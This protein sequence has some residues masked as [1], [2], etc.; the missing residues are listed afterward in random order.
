MKQQWIALSAISLVLAACGGSSGSGGDTDPDYSNLRSGDSRAAALHLSEA[1]DQFGQYLKNGMR[2]QIRIP[3]D[4]HGNGNGPANGNGNGSEQAP[5][6]EG[7]FDDAGGGSRSGNFSTTNVHV[8]GVDEADRIKY[9]GEHL[10]IASRPTPWRVMGQEDSLF[11]GQGI[12][13]LATDP[14]GAATQEVARYDFADDHHLRDL[15]LHAEA[16]VTRDVITLGHRYGYHPMSGGGMTDA[17]MIEPA[18][19]PYESGSVGS[20][21]VRAIDVTEP[22]Q[23]HT[24]WRLELDGALEQS[25]RVDNILYLVTRYTPYVDGLIYYPQTSDE[26]RAN[27]QLI[28]DTPVQ[29]LLPRYRTD[30]G[31]WQP[32]VTSERCYL[33]EER[34]PNDGFAHLV[35]IAAI[36][37][38]TRELVSS[39]C[40]NTRVD[41]FHASAT[42]LYLGAS[43]YA[44]SEPPR[45]LI[46]KF[47][48][49]EGDIEY[50]G[51]GDV[52]GALG[53][54]ALSFR[55][56]EYQGDLRVV[57]SESVFPNSG[58]ATDDSDD[59]AVRPDNGNGNGDDAT[60]SPGGGGWDM[61][62]RLYVLREQT[63]SN[64][65]Q[66]VSQ[67]PNDDRPA[68]IGKPREDIFAVRFTGDRGFLVTFEQIDPLY[69]LDLSN[70][71]DPRIAGELEV[72][73]FSTY[74][75]PIG[76]NYLLGIGQDVEMQEMWGWPAGV[77]VELY[78]IS[79]L[80][81]SEDPDAVFEPGVVD[82][83]VIGSSG[84]TSPALY[85]LRGFNMLQV[86]DDQLRFTLP[87]DV[88][89]NWSWQH[90][91]LYLFE[92]NDFVGEGAS[93]RQAGAM[94]AEKS[95]GS[96]SWGSGYG[97][98]ARSRMHDD[99]VFFLY[100]D[101][102]WSAFW[103]SPEGAQG[104]E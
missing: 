66:V 15:Y 56:N 65:L 43:V 84:S 83:F 19:M 91:G 97:Y 52:R 32:L 41:G 104:P 28:A 49:D 69:V 33:P 95:S 68:R 82:T 90:S 70:P 42:S 64:R 31:D 80:G 58:G 5:V 45:T 27:E 50:R 35:T 100:G 57:T 71:E 22:T 77:K 7:D 93:M 79:A 86:S 103:D 11:E 24:D 26:L 29:S 37:L 1:E 10:F 85:D 40:L 44:Q 21:Q 78:D 3:A 2:L 47:T 16:G 46:H 48:L 63:D 55:M 34:D 87:I 18:V 14:A 23:P 36:D 102:V 38:N 17:M 25:R 88:A 94:I 8:E 101:R 54:R 67:L 96:V 9:D 13:I 81:E 75:H 20:V 72:P 39:A 89:Q 99:T 53:W 74:L 62:H 30:G 51:T 12:R 73:G 6:A 60:V 98:E 76:E 61:I 59:D 92:I 4:G